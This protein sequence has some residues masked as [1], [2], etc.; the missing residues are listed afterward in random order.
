MTRLVISDANVRH[1]CCP[2]ISDRELHPL[3]SD[4]LGLWRQRCDNSR[5]PSRA[6][7]DPLDFRRWLGRLQV[8]DVIDGGQDFRYRLHGTLLVELF[9]RDLTG[10][11]LSELG[12]AADTLRREYDA[13]AR[14]R[15]PVAICRQPVPEKDHRIIDQLILPLARDGVRVDRLLVGI[16]PTRTG[17]GGSSGWPER[18]PSD[19]RPSSSRADPADEAQRRSR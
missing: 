18:S 17:D 6:D 12:H 19:R 16:V 15:R 2:D 10:R 9:G 7:F 3:L 13:C 11:H 1:G 8:L 5:L 4:L 14:E